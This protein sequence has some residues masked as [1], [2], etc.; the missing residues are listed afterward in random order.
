MAL[1]AT[2]LA[3]NYCKP[4]AGETAKGSAHAARFHSCSIHIDFKGIVAPIAAEMRA[5]GAG[6][7][8]TPVV[9]A[10]GAETPKEHMMRLAR[11]RYNEA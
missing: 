2:T 3:T 6:L 1:A 4:W 10:E 11:S 8:A 9:A 7:G 5:Q